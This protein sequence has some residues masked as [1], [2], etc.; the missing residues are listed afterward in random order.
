MQEPEKETV[1]RF[2]LRRERLTGNPYDEIFAENAAEFLL[3][4][5]YKEIV[6]YD[7]LDYKKC[8]WFL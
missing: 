4:L 6:T 8:R 1:K 7:D 3:E 2:F 5:L